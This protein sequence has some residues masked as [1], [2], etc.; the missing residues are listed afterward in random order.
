MIKSIVLADPLKK[1]LK[2]KGLFP[3]EIKDKFYWCLET[4]IK[5][6]HHPSLRHKKIQGTTDYWEFSVTMNYRCVY[7]REGEII[8]LLALG[9]HEDIF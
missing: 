4:L 6:E 3:T 8:F 2:K 9:K 1:K 5:D 7:R